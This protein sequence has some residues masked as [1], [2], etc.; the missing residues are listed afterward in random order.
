MATFLRY[1]L[2]IKQ[3][4]NINYNI[5]IDSQVK[6]FVRQLTIFMKYTFAVTIIKNCLT[7]KIQ[8]IIITCSSFQG[9]LPYSLVTVAKALNQLVILKVTDSWWSL[10]SKNWHFRK[11][12]I[13]TKSS[14]ICRGFPT[15]QNVGFFNSATLLSMSIACQ[16]N[17]SGRTYF[18]IH[19]V[20]LLLY[21]Q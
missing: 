15:F 18:N 6:N 20:G 17:T 9:S 8:S 5:T 16:F 7:F 12:N 14:I 19:T 11:K 10:Y 2:Y 21:W 3:F 13:L 1:C 4:C